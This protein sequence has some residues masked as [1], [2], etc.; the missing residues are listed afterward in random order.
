LR[1]EVNA[2]NV[3]DEFISS[4]DDIGSDPAAEDLRAQ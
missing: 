4:E 2:A 3:P 1:S